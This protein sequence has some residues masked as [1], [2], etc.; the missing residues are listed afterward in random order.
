MLLALSEL[1]LLSSTALAQV[2]FHP[3]VYKEK[4]AR[5]LSASPK[6]QNNYATFSLAPYVSN[7]LLLQ[8]ERKEM[9]SQKRASGGM[10][11]GYFQFAKAYPVDLDLL[12]GT[13]LD[14][15][16]G[17]RVW[18]LAI[19][20]RSAKSLHLLFSDFEMPADAEMYV[21]AIGEGAET[22]VR[23]P[24]TFDNNKEHRQFS[25][26][27]V[28]SNKILLEIYTAAA[29]GDE[30]PWLSISHIVHGYKDTNGRSGTCNIN[31]ACKDAEE[32][33]SQIN[34]VAMIMTNSGQG[35]CSVFSPLISFCV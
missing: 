33:S 35:Y 7:E 30:K 29:G 25:F 27:P 14:L 22:D 32:W 20:S 9:L 10:S 2:V 26:L 28:H 31:V 17:K 1:L 23:G 21:S 12:D 8:E 19:E 11:S 16:D 24:F 34:G 6:L 18:R 3:G 5:Y 4:F 13:W 15:P